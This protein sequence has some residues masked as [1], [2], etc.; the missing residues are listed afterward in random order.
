MDDT[1]LLVLPPIPCSTR[2]ATML[3]RTRIIEYSTRVAPDFVLNP[4]HNFCN[5][6]DIYILPA[7]N[8]D[9]LF[10]AVLPT[11]PTK[12][13]TFSPSRRN[14]DNIKHGPLNASHPQH[15]SEL[16]TC[17]R[18]VSPNGY[19]RKFPHISNAQRKDT[20]LSPLNLAGAE[21]YS[22]SI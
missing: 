10:Y 4:N 9:S 11:L 19:P 2:T 17:R 18:H 5:F 20:V 15:C 21:H 7:A 16:V 22:D 14:R 1:M 3:T 8:T 6:F 13:V 12:S